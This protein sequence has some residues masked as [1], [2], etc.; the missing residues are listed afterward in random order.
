MSKSTPYGVFNPKIGSSI[1]ET[2]QFNLKAPSTPDLGYIPGLPGGA[3]SMSG[4]GGG[5]G[6]D[7]IPKLGKL[8]EAAI[9]KLASKKSP[10]TTE[11]PS[12]KAA[13]EVETADIVAKDKDKETTEEKT[14]SDKGGFLDNFGFGNLFA[15]GGAAKGSSSSR[16]SGVDIGSLTNP[17]GPSHLAFYS[18]DNPIAS[19]AFRAPYNTGVSVRQAF[20]PMGLGKPISSSLSE[21]RLPWSNVSKG[22]S[23]FNQLL[24]DAAKIGRAHV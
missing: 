6:S 7:T 8:A 1:S 14:S 11:S 10:T 20:G 19:A 3:K 18:A 16:A 2:P 13:Q 17:R 12:T 5:G 15:D 23:K 22:S 21:F 9:T 4:S 24:L